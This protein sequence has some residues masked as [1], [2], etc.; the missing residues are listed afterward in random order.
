[1]EDSLWC[2]CPELRWTRIPGIGRSGSSPL[3]TGTHR[4]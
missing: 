4:P 2:D 1:M 3:A